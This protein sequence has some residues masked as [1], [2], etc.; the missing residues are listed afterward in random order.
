M[1]SI[2]DASD[3]CRRYWEPRRDCFVEKRLDGVEQSPVERSVDVAHLV[4][5][6]VGDDNGVAANAIG[7]KN[8]QALGARTTM[9]SLSAVSG[10]GSV[11]ATV[12]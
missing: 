6:V 10:S 7:A 4:Q 12:S 1:W 8:V 2:P 5:D 3:C 9:P 11:S